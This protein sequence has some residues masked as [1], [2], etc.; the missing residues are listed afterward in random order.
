MGYITHHINCGTMCAGDNPV[1]SRIMP[2]FMSCH[3]LV[4][5]TNKGLLLIDTG[6]G[7]EEVKRPPLLGQLFLLTAKPKLDEAETALRQIEAMGYHA[8]DVK[9]IVVT[10]LHLDHAGGIADFPDARVHVHLP[11][12]NVA[13]APKTALQKGGYLKH[14]WREA[15]WVKHETMGEKWFGFEAVHPLA[16]DDN[17]LLI[18]LPGHSP[19]HCG[20]AVNTTD[21]WLLH[22]GDAYFEQKEMTSEKGRASFGLGIYQR[23]MQ[24]NKALRLHNKD[25]LRQLYQGHSS[26][27]KLICSHDHDDY[28]T[29]CKPE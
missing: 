21:G 25:R 11:E 12:Y 13:Q 7:L 29:Y 4:V 19:G 24:D 27:V 5:E 16:G 26:E 9:H 10:H 22:C 15:K 2:R 18:P 6:F 14:Q 1:F 20:V 23:M 3:C 28:C 17:V 8:R